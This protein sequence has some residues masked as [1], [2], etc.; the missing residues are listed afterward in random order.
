MGQGR[1]FKNTVEVGEAEL[2]RGVKFGKESSIGMCMHQSDS[3][4]VR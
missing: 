2:K 1:I 4:R 3:R